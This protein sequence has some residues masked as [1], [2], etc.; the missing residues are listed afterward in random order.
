MTAFRILLATIFAVVVFFGVPVIADHGLLP[1]LPVFFGDV[2]AT[3]WRGRL[4]LDLIGFLVL[5]GTWLA[6]R[7]QFSPAGIGLGFGGL[8]LGAP[9]LSAYLY[10]QSYRVEGDW[11]ALLLGP[12]RARASVAPPATAS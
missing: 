6:W 8:L 10:V 7:N 5:S 11:A 4:N 12:E 3:E 2:P 1:L 9:F